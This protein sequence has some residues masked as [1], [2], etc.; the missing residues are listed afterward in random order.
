MFDFMTGAHM[1]TLSLNQMPS[2]TH[3]LRGQSGEAE[4]S[5]PKNMVLASGN[6]N[7]YRTVSNL[8]A[9]SSTQS[10]GGDQPHNNLM[11]YATINFII[12]LIGNLIQ[13]D[14]K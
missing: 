14:M 7:T 11:P 6:E 8:Q 5:S 4:S 12:A 2:H 1:V 10:V 3:Q 13:N 9:L